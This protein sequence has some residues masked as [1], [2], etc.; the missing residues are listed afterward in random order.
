[1]R[2]VMFSL[3]GRVELAAFRKQRSPLPQSTEPLIALMAL[4][5]RHGLNRQHAAE[6]LW[7]DSD[8]KAAMHNLATTIWRMKKAAPEFAEIFANSDRSRL[9]LSPDT[10]FLTDLEQFERRARV[11]IDA[12]GQPSQQ[13]V[14]R[15]EMAVDLYQGDAFPGID[16]EWAILERERLRGLF[17]ELLFRLTQIA[18]ANGDYPRTVRYAERLARMDPYRE[19]VHRLLMQAHMLQGNRAAAIRQYRTCQGELSETLGV[20]P[21]PETVELYESLV[22]REDRRPSPSRVERQATYLRLADAGL[23]T[24]LQRQSAMRSRLEKV[25][26]LIRKAEHDMPG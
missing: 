24:V 22:A 13:C 4:H 26:D 9:D 8:R 5:G 2:R 3:F 14:R 16:Q 21:M 6:L 17:C 18:D 7:P 19:D 1:M 20:E 25:R 11:L 12:R 10:R 23:D 15:A